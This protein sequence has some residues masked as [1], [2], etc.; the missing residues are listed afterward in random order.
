MQNNLAIGI[1]AHVDAGKTTLSEAMLFKAGHLKRL[2]RVDHRDTFL[3]TNEMERRRGITV[4]SKQAI[5]SFGESTFTLIDTPGHI[6]FSGE[7]ERTLSVLDYAILVIS[8][9]DGVQ[10]H[11]ETLWQLL[12]QYNIPTFLFVNKMDLPET[13]RNALLEDIK[14]QL[15]ENCISFSDR[16]NDRGFEEEIAMCDEE[17]LADFLKN[18][19][20]DDAAVAS[21]IR[22]RKL[23]PC[24]FGSALKLK[25]VDDFLNGLQRYTATP[26]YPDEFGAMVY[27]ISRDAQN[28]RLTH[29]KVTG[30]TL[31]VKDSLSNTNSAR[32]DN[33]SG[34]LPWAEKVNQIRIYSG[35]KYQTTDKAFPGTICAV[36]GLNHTYPG[37]G[38]GVQNSYHSPTLEPVL[39]FRLI[40]PE[41]YD[42]HVALRQLRELEEEDPLLAISWN[43]Q[44]QEIHLQLMGEVQ[45]EVFSQIVSDRF[46]MEI[47]FGKGKVVYKETISEPVIGMAHFEPLRHYAEVHILMEPA[48]RGSGLHFDTA[49]SEDIL[50]RNWQQS[51]LSHLKEREH[52]GVLAG[53]PITDMKITLLTG[54][55]HNKH[56]EGGDFRQAAYRAIR[57]GLMQAKCLLLEPWYQFRLNIPN[58]SV[59]RAMTDL[60]RITDDIFLSSSDDSRTFLTGSAPAVQLQ[61]YSSEIASYTRGQG[62]LSYTFMGFAPCHNQEAILSEQNYDAQRDVENPSDSVFCFDGASV[63]VKWDE[64]KEHIH[65]NSGFVI[66]QEGQQSTEA[67]QAV[68]RANTHAESPKKSQADSTLSLDKAS[69]S[70]DKELQEIYEKTYGPVKRRDFLPKPIR[71]HKKTE[72]MPLKGPAPLIYE[73]PDYLLVDGY[74]IIYAWED[75]N[76]L[77]QDNMDAARHMLMDIL[78]NYR[79]FHDREIILVFDAYRVKGGIT[80]TERYHNIT[81]VYTKQAETADTYIEKTTYQMGKKHRVTVASADG[82][83]QLII[84]GHGALRITPRA[85]RDEIEQTDADIS[86]I[87]KKNHQRA[88]LSSRITLPK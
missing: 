29:L 70:L 11:T 85:L 32:L 18:D 40:L 79:E 16:Q 37:L 68:Y 54:K 84:G 87:I 76:I 5:L 60:Q 67:A 12:A 41:S 77:S 57:Q 48:E 9:S 4:F 88:K 21:L 2:G 62:R 47:T 51:I 64:V 46:G 78:S 38:L 72:P 53:M 69:S 28:N 20:I 27:K 35:E 50:A 44:T 71:A 6:D 75:L 39:S 73:K 3:D 43:Q 30:G 10:G 52:V 7:A 58:E 19:R 26:D 23:F 22:E 66:P 24:F 49:C 65:L 33:L 61:N 34:E 45:M 74:N 80:K 25:G 31:T 82:T 15:H 83:I 86:D 8:G 81:V 36:T 59:G 42:P 55:A 13:S 1:L 17:T 56:T 14:K 63:I